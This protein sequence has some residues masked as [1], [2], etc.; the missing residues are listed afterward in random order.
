MWLSEPIPVARGAVDSGV[1]AECVAVADFRAR[2]AALP[3]QVLGFQ[4][5]AGERKNLVL[6]AQA[7]VSVNDHVRMQPATRA[8]LDVLADDTIRTNLAIRT[9]AGLGMDDG[10][11]VN[12]DDL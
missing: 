3:F 11:G 9:D 12:H 7:R 2:Q 1:F 10:R 6:I 5:N 8:Q 4:S